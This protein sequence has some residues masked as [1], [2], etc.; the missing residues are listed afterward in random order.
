MLFQMKL[1]YSKKAIR[2]KVAYLM[3]LFGI[4]VF[5]TACL[6]K[7]AVDVVFFMATVDLRY[8]H[9]YIYG[10]IIYLIFSIVLIFHVSKCVVEHTIESFDKIQE[11]KDEELKLNENALM[12]TV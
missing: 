7:F 3:T 8:A 11:I 4:A 2:H 10:G 9:Y 5:I 6:I 1:N 12:E